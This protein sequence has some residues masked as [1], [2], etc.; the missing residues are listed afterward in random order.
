[1]LWPGIAASVR[2]VRIPKGRAESLRK[3]L[4]KAGLV[5]KT[6]AIIE[7]GESVVL[8][9]LG[10]PNSKLLRDEGVEMVDAQFPMRQSRRDPIDEIRAIAAVP[11]M[12]RS[13][14]P[15]KWE[16]LG[17][18]LVIRLDR[19]LDGFETEVARAYAAVLDART[20]IRDIGGVAGT[21]RQPVTRILLGDDAETIHVENRIKFK[22]DASKIMYSSGNLDERI[23]MSTVRCDGETVVDMFAGIG[24]F[25]IP[26]AVYQKPAR[27][28]ACEINPEAFRYLKENTLSNDV[29]GTVTPVLG[30]NR[31][32]EGCGIADRV[33]MG[34]VKTT[35]EFLP[36]AMRLLRSGGT[37]HYHETCPNELLPKRPIERLLAN[38]KGGRVEVLRFRRLK[39]YAPGVTHVVVDAR[40][41]RSS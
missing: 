12:L 15:D 14:L 9:L 21:Y 41:F 13:L 1:M 5:D 22:F 38:V 17:D 25:S 29:E 18:V 4:A 20:V 36:T 23:R 8:P 24:Y 7:I 37:I 28:I 2:G 19:K 30:D 11:D 35:H 27:V 32:L 39:S 34:Y 31:D 3:D 26:L 10:D 40:V 33:I 6:H 16:L